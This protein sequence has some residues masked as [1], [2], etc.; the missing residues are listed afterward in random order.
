M[1][2]GVIR[3][4]IGSVGEY[5]DAWYLEKR[6]ETGG[7]YKMIVYLKKGR[8]VKLVILNKRPPQILVDRDARKKLR[9]ILPTEFRELCKT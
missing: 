8:I 3:F 5:D 1:G 4:R 7:G 2:Y 6:W 9:R